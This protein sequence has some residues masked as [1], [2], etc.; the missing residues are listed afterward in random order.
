MSRFL[1]TLIVAGLLASS[2]SAGQLNLGRAALPDEV[3]AWNIDV[4]AD[5]QGLPAGSGSVADGEALFTEQCAACH[6]DFGEAVGRWPALAGGNGTLAEERPVKTIGS[7]WPYLSTA[8]DY[9]YRAMPYGNAQSLT[10]DETY[11]L[12]AYILYLN[13]MVD[14]GF[15]LS[16]E[17][18]TGIEMANTD[19]FR[20]DDR[21]N[22]EYPT[23]KKAACMKDCKPIVQITKRAV[24]EVSSE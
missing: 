21:S 10:P 23:F 2:V 15:V 12:V 18:F 6:G 22:A 11:Q 20:L 9:I 8:Y 24:R 13:D 1:R 16:R 14:E 7:F 17:N 5:G 3:A 19:N 4:R